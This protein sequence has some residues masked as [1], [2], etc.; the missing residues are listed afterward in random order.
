[1]IVIGYL[2]GALVGVA[3][4]LMGGGGSILTV[5]I[6]VYVLGYDPKLAIAMSL[7]VIGTTS[8]VGAVRH[9]RAGNV[10]LRTAVTFGAVAMC[11]AFLGARLGT[12]LA[13]AVQLSLLAIVMLLAAVFM[14]RSARQS[15]AVPVVASDAVPPMR[16]GLLVPAAITVGVITGVA[17]VGGGFLV[18][19]ALVILARTP[20]RHAVG[21]SLL[22]IAMNAASAFVGYVGE[23]SFPWSFMLR[24]TLVAVVGILIGTSMVQ[25]VSQSALKRSFAVFLVVMGAFMLYQ[26]RT[27]FLPPADVMTQPR[28][29]A[30]PA[31]GPP[32][33]CTLASKLRCGPVAPRRDG[34]TVAW[35][36]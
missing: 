17:G 5:P 25:Y 26:N 6:F 29:L 21:T 13:G 11:G 18:V 2:L 34:R 22:V 16:A 9:W 8:L 24:F 7:P 14:F 4:G 12:V 28:A 33:A 30:A 20:I 3:L 31:N 36:D 15:E 10:S 19:P 32:H 35:A 27:I 23:T 1:M